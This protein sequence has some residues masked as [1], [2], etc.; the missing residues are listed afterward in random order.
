MPRVS[1]HMAATASALQT[2]LIP[3]QPVG[4]GVRGR[5]PA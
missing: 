1:K 4:H 3:L 5:E 2:K